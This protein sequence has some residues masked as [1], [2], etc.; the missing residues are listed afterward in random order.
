MEE[1]L[2]NFMF[3]DSKEISVGAVNKNYREMTKESKG[4][5]SGGSSKD[6]MYSEETQVSH[7]QKSKEPKDTW[8]CVVVCERQVVYQSWSSIERCISRWLN[9]KIQLFPYQNSRSFFICFTQVEA[10]RIAI[11]GIIPLEGQP[12]LLLYE[13][14]PVLLNNLKKV[15]GDVC[16]GL[17]EVDKRI[18]RRKYLYEAQIMVKNNVL[19]FLPEVVKLTQGEQSYFVQIRLL[20]PAIQSPNISGSRFLFLDS[21]KLREIPMNFLK[22]S[23]QANGGQK[24]VTFGSAPMSLNSPISSST[25]CEKTDDNVDKGKR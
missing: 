24:W 3:G 7:A 9:R 20:S 4:I 10:T 16:G 22:S 1:Y 6:S 15:I 14:I 13:W 25:S 23:N 2:E 8:G 17:I 5:R 11:R 12:D 21:T 18:E 19:G